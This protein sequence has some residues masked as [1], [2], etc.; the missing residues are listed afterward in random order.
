[1]PPAAPIETSELPVD[2][3]LLCAHRIMPML[4]A[5]RAVYASSPE[6]TL[7]KTQ[8]SLPIAGCVLICEGCGDSTMLLVE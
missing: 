6:V 5:P 1:M 3:F 8:D 4:P 2:R 7:M